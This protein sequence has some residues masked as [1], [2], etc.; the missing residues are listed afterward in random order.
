MNNG[1]EQHWWVRADDWMI[2]AERVL[3]VLPPAPDPFL[4]PE[5]KVELPDDFT[6]L[7]LDRVQRIRRYMTGRYVQTEL[8]Y[9][10]LQTNFEVED[11]E[12]TYTPNEHVTVIGPN[13][14]FG[15][16][17]KSWEI[18]TGRPGRKTPPPP[19]TETPADGA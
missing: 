5:P 12:F 8:F 14:L 11:S 17:N 3:R 7:M 18:T 10:H 19:R 15:A 6:D 13:A 16:L 4:D 2:V 1:L 9:D